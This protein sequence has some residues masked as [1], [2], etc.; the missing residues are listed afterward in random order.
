MPPNVNV[1]PYLQCAAVSGGVANPPIR[2]GN[3][4]FVGDPNVPCNVTGSPAATNVLQLERDNVAD[5]VFNEAQGVTVLGT[6]PLFTVA[7]K[8]IGIDVNPFPSASATT[9]VGTPALIP[10]TITNITSGNVTFNNAGAFAFTGTDAAD[11]TIVPATNTCAGATL[12]PDPPV[13]PAV[14]ACTFEVQFNPAATA[15][16]AR[17]AVLTISADDTATA[18]PVVVDLQGTAQYQLTVTTGANGTFTNTNGAAAVSEAVNAGTSKTYRATPATGYFPLVKSN[19]VRQTLAADGSV[20][21]ATIAEHK[22]INATFLR[23]GDL[24]Q[25]GT[26]AVADALR[27]LR[28]FVGVTPAQTD[29]ENVAA[30]VGP[31]VSNAPKANGRVD[32]SDVIVILRRALNLEPLW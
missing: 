19:N 16:A 11:F 24:D 31:L 2:V 27:A 18:P 17:T 5:G 9:L 14:S 21:L 7:G 30:D 13:A 25:N 3:E 1:G 6:T 29:E 26:I 22:T 12:V 28:I 32:I 23:N 20:T 8:K 10:F 4:F 15:V